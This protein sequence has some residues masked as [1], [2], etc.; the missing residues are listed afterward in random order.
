[1]LRLKSLIFISYS[2]SCHCS[3]TWASRKIDKR[4]RWLSPTT[5]L[6]KG[7]IKGRLSSLRERRKRQADVTEESATTRTI[8]RANDHFSHVAATLL[9]G[10]VR[11]ASRRRT[12]RIIYTTT[13]T[14]QLTGAAQLATAFP[15][16][17]R[18]MFLHRRCFS[19]LFIRCVSRVF[20]ECEDW[21]KQN[22]ATKSWTVEKVD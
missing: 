5:G 3:H 1:M 11:R 10:D 8:L 20:K 6:T 14:R 22:K 12:E 17:L 7:E 16:F 15:S 13:Y 19:L 9:L 4:V 18:S 21:I 2:D